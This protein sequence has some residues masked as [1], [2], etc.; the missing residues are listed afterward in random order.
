MEM[1]IIGLLVGLMGGGAAWFAARARAARELA[2]LKQQAA[3]LDAQ[4]AGLREQLDE[5]RRRESAAAQTA[6]EQSR[7]L[8]D[9]QTQLGAYVA[10][11]QRVPELERQLDERE[12]Q[13]EALRGELRAASSQLAARE[14]QGRVLEALEARS[15]QQGQDITRLTAR[16]QELATLLESERRQNQEKLALLM[17]ARQ[18]LSDQFKALAGDILEE[19][20]KRFTEQNQQNLGALLNPLNERI[21]NF[22]KLVQDTYDKDSKERLSLEV[23]LKRLQ[24]LNTRLG[25]DATALTNALTGAS[26]KAQGTWGEM[27]L[28]KVLETSGLHKGREYRVQVSDVVQTED[29]A[30]RYQPDV[31]I[32]LPEGKQLVVDSKVS[33]N[34]YVRYTAAEDDAAREAELKAHIAAIRAHIRTLSEKRYQDL[35]QLNTL[36]FVFM[37]IPVEPAYLLAVQHDMSLFNEAFE[38]RIMIVGP[39]TLLATLRTVA[40]IWRYEYQNQNAQEIARQGGAMYDKFAGFVANMEKLGKQLDS[41]RDTF[42]DAMRQLSSG[43]GNLM[44]S[45]E[46]LR[47]LG[48]RNNKQLAAQLRLDDAGDGEEDGEA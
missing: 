35:Y 3:Q 39:S 8:A 48:I 13:L 42:G 29:G 21:Q 2:E 23:E 44:S 25:D 47:K 19:K 10:R 11:A 1:L 9:G 7:Q 6:Q 43:R 36:D 40:S 34:A 26:S 12:K 28:E 24:E 5:A 45:A 46:R 18:A 17:D 4:C 15:L 37:F 30:K 33:L 27:V 22:G 20:S 32:D 41:S 31:V 14:E 16:E 38:R